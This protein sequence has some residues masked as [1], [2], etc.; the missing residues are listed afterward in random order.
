VIHQI[1]NLKTA[2]FVGS[3]LSLLILQGA[4]LPI[5]D[6]GRQLQDRANDMRL[7]FG[8]CL[9]LET[10]APLPI[11]F[12]SQGK[13]VIEPPIVRV[14][15][16]FF[17]REDRF[18]N[19]ISTHPDQQPFLYELSILKINYELL[20]QKKIKLEEAIFGDEDYLRYLERNF[21]LNGARI[22]EF[23]SRLTNLKVKWSSIT[24]KIARIRDGWDSIHQYFR[25]PFN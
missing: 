5:R 21:T 10:T 16:D 14:L 23:K 8:R 19:F 17:S 7:F 9:P 18:F 12:Y 25:I 24:E 15:F 3:F 13:M 1:K 22:E 6:N 11:I 4:S 2:L 20:C